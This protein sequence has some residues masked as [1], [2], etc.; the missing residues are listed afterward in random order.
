[1]PRSVPRNHRMARLR[2]APLPRGVA[3]GALLL[4]GLAPLEASAMEPGAAL[5]SDLDH[6]WV[7]TAAALV[8]FMQLGFMMLEAGLV[9]SKNS[10]NVAQKNLTD[11]F[12]AAACF[13]AVGYM[14]MFG[15]SLGGVVG[16]DPRLLFSMGETEAEMSFFV[17]QVVFCGA[18]GT[19]L[20]GAV[21]ER[22]RYSAYLLTMPLIAALIYPVF[23]H[24]AWGNLLIE[25]N[26]AWLADLGFVDFAG[27]T[28]VHSV[29]AWV[30]L[31]AI[32][33]V[34]PRLDR[35]DAAGKPVRI[36]GHSA[37]LATGGAIVLFIGWLGFNGGSTLSGAQGS[38]HVI[39]N[40]VLAGVI[41]GLAGVLLGWMRDGAHRPERAINGLVGG[42]VAITA[43]CDLATAPGAALLGGLGGAIAVL[44]GDWLERRGIDDAVGAVAVH[45]FAGALGTIGLALVAP[46]DALPAGGRLDQ[47][48]V[49]ALGV[50]VAFVWT[51]SL[52]LAWF[53]LLS[54]FMP[55]R[56][57]EQE[58]RDGLNRAEHGAS[59]GLGEVQRLMAQMAVGDADRSRRLTVD[60]GD[61]AAELVELF[62]R[63][64]AS[65]EAEEERRRFVDRQRQ[66]QDE[67]SLKRET[68][69]REELQQR[70]EIEKQLLEK[71]AAAVE[72]AL[73]RD[74]TARADLSG[75]TGALVEAGKG[76]NRLLDF[77]SRLVGM[78]SGNVAEIQFACRAQLEGSEGLAHTAS[79]QH[80]ALI[81]ATAQVS[82]LQKVVDEI[83]A[84]GE[85]T[86]ADMRRTQNHVLS[87]R[88]ATDQAVLA[89]RT[90][91][92]H[93]RQAHTII[94]LIED[95]AMQTGMLAINAAI[96]ASRAGVHGREFTVV[97]DEVRSLA[98]RT[99]QLS[100]QISDILSRS[101][102]GVAEAVAKVETSAEAFTEMSEGSRQVQQ[103]V[104]AILECARRQ[105]AQS[106]DLQATVERLAALG[107]ETAGFAEQNASTSRDLLEHAREL[108]AD[109]DGYRLAD[110]RAAAARAA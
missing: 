96:Q 102:E 15:P 7:M 86:D 63:L 69:R 73:D 19:I 99:T 9:R 48:G 31:A 104:A 40:T 6:V 26:T 110:D 64:M 12:V 14:M 10:I 90:V 47:L 98:Q 30:A 75:Q 92:E 80:D 76:V 45:G 43:G 74:L 51:M 65:L 88:E 95:I 36:Q 5:R 68:A 71:I 83:T 34:G 78:L 27:S 85:A 4:A 52:A 107:E 77:L 91:A 54:Q 105:A 13:A 21:A 87:G 38:A 22:F 55:L 56:V 94:E 84:L 79:A 61:E 106:A 50:A 53:W 103:N 16:F 72:A 20:S 23:G 67:T 25:G 89:M 101:A 32:I 82:D 58:E 11:F 8:L 109:V 100:V 81:G 97:S 37:V 24:W 108:N 42:L 29:G 41:G 70:Q 1:M 46:A 60:P 44:G 39:A 62:N 28:V 2:T 18:A 93:S 33:M 59:L 49:Q 35:Y 3:L 57:T 66:K 17:F